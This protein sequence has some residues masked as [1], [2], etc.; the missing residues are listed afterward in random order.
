VIDSF[1]FGEKSNILDLESKFFQENFKIRKTENLWDL[2]KKFSTPKKRG[3]PFSTIRGSGFPNLKGRKKR[4]IKK[5][6]FL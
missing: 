1:L 3:N 4:G 2:R 6:F 5:K